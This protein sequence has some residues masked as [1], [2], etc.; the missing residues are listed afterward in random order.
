MQKKIT[1][2]NYVQIKKR[3]DFLIYSGESSIKFESEHRC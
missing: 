3:I 2:K 1:F